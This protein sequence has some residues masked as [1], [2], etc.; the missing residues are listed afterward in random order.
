MSFSHIAYCKTAVAHLYF[1]HYPT[2]ALLFQTTSR[3]L[4]EEGCCRA[5]LR[6][7]EFLLISIDLGTAIKMHVMARGQTPIIAQRRHRIH[8]L[9]RL[10]NA[11]MGATVVI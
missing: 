9:H 5:G 6:E 4:M 7:R 1:S 11:L 8:R 3:G 2:N 10:T